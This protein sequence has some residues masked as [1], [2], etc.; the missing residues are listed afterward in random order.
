MKAL[1]LLLLIVVP[2]CSFADLYAGSVYYTRVTPPGDEGVYRWISHHKDLIANATGE[3]R[4]RMERGVANFERLK[5]EGRTTTRMMG[6][7]AQVDDNHSI[8]A[9][10]LTSYQPTLDS[11]S[12]HFDVVPYYSDS[13]EHKIVI[14]EDR[15]AVHDFIDGG[16]TTV[17]TNASLHSNEVWI[18]VWSHIQALDEVDWVQNN[19]KRIH[20]QEM[21][22]II[23]EDDTYTVRARMQGELHETRIVA[24]EHGLPELVVSTSPRGEETWLI[25]VKPTEHLNAETVFD[26]GLDRPDIRIIDAGG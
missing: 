20:K 11:Y 5:E 9:Y 16:T 22:T 4:A 2:L 25:R 1:I 21:V 7:V 14:G 18:S 15:Y 10:R 8:S 24:G 23:Q 6:L 3:T 17:Y 19:G 13:L 12:H 26:P